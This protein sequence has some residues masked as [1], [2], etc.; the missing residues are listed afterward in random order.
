MTNHHLT[1][2]SRNSK[3]GPMPASTSTAA[4]CPDACPLKANGCYAEHGRQAMHW[5]KVT[6]GERGSDWPGFVDIVR[7]SVYPGQLWRHNVSGDLVGTGDRIDASALADLTRANGAAHGF[8][9]THYPA[10]SGEHAAH[11]LA[12]IAQANASGFTVNLSADGLE[13]ADALADTGQPVVTILP[14]DYA[15]KREA[16][17]PAGRRVV[18]CPAVTGQARSCHDCGL[19]HRKNRRVIVGFPAHGTAKRKANAVAKRAA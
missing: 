1:A 2:V 13:I 6:A 10:T 8:T 18:V 11:N 3:L 16:V 15:D 12:A 4:T 9:Y 17:T 19:C 5:R 14:S 7:R